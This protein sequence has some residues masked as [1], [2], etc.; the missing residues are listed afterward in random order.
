MEG[1]GVKN[2]WKSFVSIPIKIDLYHYLISPPIPLF[3][4]THH[5]C[6]PLLFPLQTY[7]QDQYNWIQRAGGS[8]DDR[9]AGLGRSTLLQELY[10]LSGSE[11]VS[12]S[13]MSDSQRP[14]G[15]QPAKLLYPWDSPGKNAG[16]GCNFSHTYTISL[17][18][19]NLENLYKIIYCITVT[20]RCIYLC[21]F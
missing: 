8:L 15:L 5:G 6:C 14:H 12:P 1:K 3:P 21:I 20:Y 10:L 13:V 7:C 18:F 16:E 2:V 9:E 17:F 4:I 19:F 11:S